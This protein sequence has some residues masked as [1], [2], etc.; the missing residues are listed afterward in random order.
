MSLR[1]D[2]RW[3]ALVLVAAGL[4]TIVIG[5]VAVRWI[6]AYDIPDAAWQR[7]EITDRREAPWHELRTTWS[8]CAG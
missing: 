7:R 6:L 1:G 4:P 3:E 5:A 2:D 8:S